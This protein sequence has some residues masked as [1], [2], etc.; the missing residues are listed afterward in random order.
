MARVYM[1]TYARG[2][3]VEYMATE[4][5][6]DLEE[7]EGSWWYGPLEPP[8]GAPVVAEGDSTEPPAL[9]KEPEVTL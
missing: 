5:N 6:D 3:W 9:P 2:G 8:P 7:L 4:H 1:Q